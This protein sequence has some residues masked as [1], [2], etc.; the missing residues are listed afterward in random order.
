MQNHTP[1]ENWYNNNEFHDLNTSTSIA[2]GTERQAI[3]TYTKGLNYTDQFTQTFLQQLDQIDKPITVIFYG[4]HLPGIYQTASQDSANDITLH[5]TDYFIW[6]NA[7]SEA[8]GTK[9]SDDDSAFT[10]ANYFMAQAAE[11]LDAKVTPYLA[12]LTAMHKQIP[13]M[14]TAAIDSTNAGEPVYLDAQGERIDIDNLT[15]KQRQMLA[16]YQLIQYDMT[17][18]EQY[19]KDTDFMSMN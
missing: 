4:D 6:S 11:H 16:D 12:F 10:S 13:A 3:E 8:R 19:L 14:S 9:L 1:Y 2:D 5:E 18:G 7:A 17:A 15:L